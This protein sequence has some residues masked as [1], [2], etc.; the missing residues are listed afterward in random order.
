MSPRKPLP[1]WGA[2]E[3][4]EDRKRHVPGAHCM[5]TAGR[6]LAVGSPFLDG[7]LT[8]QE[9]GGSDV[10]SRLP[11]S[12]VGGYPITI[13]TFRGFSFSSIS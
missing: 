8:H 2:G 13:L 5:P 11:Y 1:P 9:W 4:E 10:R 12:E 6:T 7:A 3:E